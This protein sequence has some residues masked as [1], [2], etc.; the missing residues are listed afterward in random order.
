MR[1]I[2]IT[3]GVGAGK[4]RVLSFLEREYGALVIQADQVAKALEEPGAE[5]Y[6]QL[7]EAFGTGILGPD[8]SIDKQALAARIFS[9]PAALQT[10]NQIIHPL[11]WQEIRRQIAA[12]ERELVVVEAALFD[13]RSKAIC[14]E[15]WFV[16]APEAVRAARL[17][18]HRGYSLE[19]SRKMMENQP[20]RDAFLALSDRVIDNGG[21]AEETKQQLRQLLECV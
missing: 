11:T 21:T 3:G 17:L 1:V 2:G 10:V 4:S 8:G 14:E 19:K 5:G 20:S 12:S 16:D 13:E 15:L 7:C 6:R 18:E 9:D